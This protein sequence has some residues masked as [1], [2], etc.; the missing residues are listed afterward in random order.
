MFKPK[1]LII[2]GNGGSLGN[3]E[4]FANGLRRQLAARYSAREMLIQNVILKDDFFRLL[5][6]FSK[7][8]AAVIS[9]LHIISHAIGGGLFTGYGVASVGEHRVS[10]V[11]RAIDREKRLTYEEV[12]ASEI[13]A[14]LTDDFLRAEIRG[15]GEKYRM[16]LAPAATIKIW[17]C[18]SGIANWVYSDNGERDPR[19]VDERIAFYWRAL[20]LKNSPKPAVAQA[21]ADFFQRKTFGAKSGAHV[22]VLHRGAW[23]SSARYRSEVNSWPSPS[24]VHRLHPDRGVYHTFHPGPLL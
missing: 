3:L 4:V 18:N 10:M 13:G 21:F 19:V 11:Q 17:G 23:V 6:D 5:E 7:D 8:H 1:A 14:I 20:N 15:K 24:L 12:V 2:Y 9:E 22:E 16:A